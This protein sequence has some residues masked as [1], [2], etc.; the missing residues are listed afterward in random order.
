MRVQTLAVLPMYISQLVHYSW[1]KP[2][3]APAQFSVPGVNLNNCWWKTTMGLDKAE[4]EKRE[5][6]ETSSEDLLSNSRII[7][8]IICHINWKQNSYISRVPSAKL[9]DLRTFFVISLERVGWYHDLRFIISNILLLSFLIILN[10]E[11]G[12]DLTQSFVVLNIFFCL[13]E[14]E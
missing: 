9:M 13:F 6:V 14:D 5:P 8:N 7:L 2:D 3:T 12:C 11:F 10:H 1:S 4:A